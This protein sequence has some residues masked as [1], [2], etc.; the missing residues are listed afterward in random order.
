[1]LMLKDGRLE[2]LCRT[3]SRH[4]GITYSSDNGLTWTPLELIDMPNN[5]S[6]IDAVTLADGRHALICNDWPIEPTKEKGAR[7]PLSVLLSEDGRTWQH[8]QTLEDSPISQYSYPSII[9]S[10]DGHLHAIYTWRRQRIKH[11]ELV[12]FRPPIVKQ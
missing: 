12:P 2:A 8:F 7:T 3:R 6:G 10:R 9:Q 4:I 1:M 11:V 5:N